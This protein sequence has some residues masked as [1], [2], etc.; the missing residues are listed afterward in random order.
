AGNAFANGAITPLLMLGLALLWVNRDRPRV[1]SW[2]LAALVVTKVFLLPLFLWL[3]VTRR[4]RTAAFAAGATAL[5][6]VLGWAAIGFKG[7]TGYPH[8]LATL[9]SAEQAVSYSPL[10][11]ALSAGLSGGIAR[12]VVALLVGGVGALWLRARR[13]P[14]ADEL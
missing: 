10:S 11:L 4:L 8:L 2:L 9:S 1:A 13:P 6:A 12:L 5:L 14:H 7:L 3:L